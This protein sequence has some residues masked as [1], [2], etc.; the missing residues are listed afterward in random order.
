MGWRD[1]APGVLGCTDSDLSSGY[2]FGQSVDFDLEGQ[3]MLAGTSGQDIDEEY[4][5][6]D[7]GPRVEPLFPT[8]GTGQNYRDRSFGRRSEA[9]EHSH[10]EMAAGGLTRN[11]RIE[12]REEPE[13][14]T[15]CGHRPGF[16]FVRTVRVSVRAV[17]LAAPYGDCSEQ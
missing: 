12:L 17:V 8:G 7:N 5:W 2:G 14:V 10:M 4:P 6:A 1:Q 15:P 9:I 11:Q 16:C 3:L 13:V